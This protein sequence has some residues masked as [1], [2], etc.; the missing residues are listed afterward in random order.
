MT[1]NLIYDPSSPQTR[2]PDPLGVND[3]RCV[4][5]EN[6]MHDY[7]GH[8]GS[9]GRRRAPRGYNDELAASAC[10]SRGSVEKG[11]SGDTGRGVGLKVEAVVELLLTTRNQTY[12]QFLVD[13]RAAL[14]EHPSGRLIL[15]ALPLI[16]DLVHQ[17][18]QSR[19][20]RFRG[21]QKK[22]DENFGVP[23]ASHL[24]RY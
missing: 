7:R 18:G 5:E 4:T 8:H 14:P 12:A 22:R 10:S 1:D 23:Q 17:R 24:G 3:D 15:V 21:R 20:H 9:G 2:R 16:N 19:S 6:A 13:S 11:H